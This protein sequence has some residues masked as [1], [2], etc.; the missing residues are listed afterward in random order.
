[1]KE[2]T[3][4]TLIDFFFSLILELIIHFG[5]IRWTIKNDFN[6]TIVNGLTV[7]QLANLFVYGII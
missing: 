5:A 2:K 1:M 7:S 4:S 6:K 3:R